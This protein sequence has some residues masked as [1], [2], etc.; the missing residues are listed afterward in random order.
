MDI[1][2]FPC[3]LPQSL[4]SVELPPFPGTDIIGGDP[5]LFSVGVSELRLL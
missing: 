1:F 5:A 2:N 4:V 3:A